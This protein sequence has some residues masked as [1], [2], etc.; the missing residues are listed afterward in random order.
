M[1]TI[2]DVA[3]LAG[4]SV[5]TV[6]RVLNKNG[7]VNKETEQKVVKAMQQL[8]YE[9]NAVAR[10]LA[11]KQ[12]GTIALILPDISNPFF[13]ELARGIEDAAQRLGFTVI[14]CNSDD[15]GQKEK[16][17]IEV[18]RKKYVDGI[19]FASNTLG[20]E[21]VVQ[22]KQS[23][24]PFV[25]LDRAVA[26]Q[27]CT[28]IRCNNYEGAKMAVQHLLDIGCQKIA[29][30]YGPQELIT[31]RERLRGY[32]ETVKGFP[33]YSPSLMVPGSF[34]FD[35]G[36]QAVEELLRLH[37]DV[38]G[39]FAGND[40]MA[41]GVLKGLKRKGIAVPDQIAVCGFDG[42]SLTEIAEPEL[43]TVAQPIYEM[44][45]MAAEV[46]IKKIKTGDTNPGLFELEVRLIQRDSTRKR[47][48]G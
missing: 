15:Q 31:A 41:L 33:W 36:L 14:L 5:A 20:Q 9:P 45:A 35:G 24:L 4:V 28:V 23:S 12:T 40:L 32:E 22:M 46:L 8:Q 38:D 16:S 7:Y 11:G 47:V 3:K 18:L 1:A 26:N 48:R 37:P 30:I 43:T 42:I 27:V 44:G 21:E 29:H 2:R 34:R 17:Y 39:I 10:G 25:I 6:S 19:I 13:P